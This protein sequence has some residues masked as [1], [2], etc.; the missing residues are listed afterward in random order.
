MLT[1]T[2]SDCV[3]SKYTSRPY[4]AILVQLHV[5]FVAQ[6]K[7]TGSVRGIVDMLHNG[8]EMK[9][10]DIPSNIYIIAHTP[11]SIIFHTI[12]P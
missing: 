12:L 3:C 6:H 2:I 11:S 1:S 4:F 10:E 9:A 5:S 7:C 8:N